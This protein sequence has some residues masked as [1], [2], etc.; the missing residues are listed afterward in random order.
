MITHVWGMKFTDDATEVAKQ[1]FVH[2]MNN[3]PEEIQG[4]S[5]FKAGTDLGLN[6]G[7]SDVTIVAEFADEEAWKNYI[8]HPVHVA[9]VETH[10]T[11]ICKSWN[12]IQFEA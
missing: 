9:F 7:N 11:P 12:A 5:S 3:L 4:V 10:V 6:E 1:E 2:A 8:Q